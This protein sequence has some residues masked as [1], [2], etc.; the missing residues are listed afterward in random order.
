MQNNHLTFV[1]KNNYE[2]TEGLDT[3]AKGIGLKNVKKRLQ[4]LYPQR[5]KL[6]INESENKFS[7]FLTLELE[8]L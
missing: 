7:V 2:Q 5:H 8:K 6:K 4:L 3:V 1:C